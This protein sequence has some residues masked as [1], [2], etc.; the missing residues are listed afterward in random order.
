VAAGAFTASIA[1][2]AGMSMTDEKLSAPA[3]TRGRKFQ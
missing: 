3:L 2:A 1:P